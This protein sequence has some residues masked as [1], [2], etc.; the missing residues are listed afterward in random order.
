MWMR[1]VVLDVASTRDD[2]HT[3]PALTRAHVMPMVRK[4]QANKKWTGEETLLGAA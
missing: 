1:A 2:V 4:E 3:I